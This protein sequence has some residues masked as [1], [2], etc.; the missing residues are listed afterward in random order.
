MYFACV[1]FVIL[2]FCWGLGKSTN[3][4]HVECMRFNKY[5]VKQHQKQCIDEC[6]SVCW[7]VEKLSSNGDVVF[8]YCGVCIVTVQRQMG[9]TRI[10]L[11]WLY[12][13]S[14]A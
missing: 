5:Q 1:S 11:N 6:G 3:A 2:G 10:Q 14:N 12:L 9:L 7:I 4:I 8:V 13:V